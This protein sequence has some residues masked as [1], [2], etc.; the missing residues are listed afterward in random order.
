MYNN[1]CPCK[2][3]FMG[4]FPC[5]H[6]NIWDTQ[7]NETQTHTVNLPKT[8]SKL[9][10][11][12]KL[13]SEY[14]MRKNSAISWFFI[15]CML[16]GTECWACYWEMPWGRADKATSAFLCG[17]FRNPCTL[18]SSFNDSCVPFHGRTSQGFIAATCK[19]QQTAKNRKL[20]V[21]GRAADHVA[22]CP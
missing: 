6:C 11:T 18:H 22:F 21:L 9:P 3:E 16:G 20:E 10:V 19:Q 1:E 8:C 4:R 2:P 7:T 15:P 5:P 14:W 13:S 12:L 17:Y